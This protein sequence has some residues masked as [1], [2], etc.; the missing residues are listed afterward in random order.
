MAAL[1]VGV[2]LAFSI[3]TRMAGGMNMGT[4]RKMRLMA[5][6]STATFAQFYDLPRGSPVVLS[7]TSIPVFISVCRMKYAFRK[8]ALETAKKELSA[9]RKTRRLPLADASCPPMAFLMPRPTP[10]A[11][12][13]AIP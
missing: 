13:V 12:V 6:W 9:L 5:V 8:P 1:F 11:E 4:T 10:M 3:P 2:S 7:R